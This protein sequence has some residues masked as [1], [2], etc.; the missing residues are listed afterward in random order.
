MR[1]IGLSEWFSVYGGLICER[2][3]LRFQEEAGGAALLQVECCVRTASLGSLQD[4][5]TLWRAVIVV[6]L[7][8][9]VRGGV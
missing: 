1:N 8:W 5:M 2:N 4:E 6:G 7:L 3:H 9:V